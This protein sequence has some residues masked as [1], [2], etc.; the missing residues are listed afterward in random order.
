M[1]DPSGITNVQLA[2][3]NLFARVR[4]LEEQAGTT[5]EQQGLTLR[6]IGE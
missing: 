5:S 6:W 2:L 1:A 3:N 4:A